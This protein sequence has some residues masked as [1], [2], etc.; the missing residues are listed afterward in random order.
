MLL[1]FLCERTHLTEA[2]VNEVIQE[3]AS[4]SE[5]PPKINGTALSAHAEEGHLLTLPL[6]A[7]VDLSSLRLE[8]SMVSNLSRQLDTLSA[9][10]AIDQLQRLERSVL[11]L[12]RVNVQTLGMLSKLVNA[13]KKAPSED[14][15]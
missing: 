12:E 3:F 8:P 13:V 15:K 1:G 9:G 10:Q 11:R 6:D 7:N 5:V 2:D 14:V 4:E